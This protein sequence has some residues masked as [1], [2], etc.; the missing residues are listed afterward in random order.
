MDSVFSTYHAVLTDVY[1]SLT[2]SGYELWP[3][4]EWFLPSPATGAHCCVPAHEDAQKDPRTPVVRVLCHLRQD[5]T[6]HL[7]GNAAN[8]VCKCTWYD[9]CV[10]T[11]VEGASSKWV[12][13]H[14]CLIVLVLCLFRVTSCMLCMCECYKVSF[15]YQDDQV[16]VFPVVNVLVG[17][18]YCL[19]YCGGMLLLSDAQL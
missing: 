2:S 18:N 13:W 6:T 1:L 10:C 4:T 9:A 14:C 11:G 16:S 7:H 15:A 12:H 8:F 17:G 3:S 19:P 5:R